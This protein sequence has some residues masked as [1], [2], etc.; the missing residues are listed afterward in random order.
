MATS[1]SFDFNLTRNDIITAAY[2]EIGVVAFGQTPTPDQFVDASLKLNAM[3]KAWKAEGIQLWTITDVSLPIQ[4]TSVVN[5]SDGKDYEATQTHTSTL[6][7]EP[8]TGAN[9]K[10]FWNLLTTTAAGA[11]TVA[12][13]FTS[14]Q[15]YI[16]NQQV[17]G[18]DHAFVRQ[19]NTDTP[20][21][22]LSRFDYNN[23][24]S[25]TTKGKPT[26]FYFKRGLIP[27][28]F[29]Y[30]FPTNTTDFIVNLATIQF[31]QDFDAAS[32]NPDFVQEWLETLIENLALRLA[33]KFGITGQRYA[34]L[35][36][37]ADESKFLAKGGDEE[38]GDLRINP[39][40]RFIDF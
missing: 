34:Q 22:E 10:L 8:I 4:A 38:L 1:G 37:K 40:L 11:W 2:Q 31:P 33:P 29:L 13:A 14:S 20:L 17:F 9:F 19:D 16:L 7:D 28:L 32:D 18:I 23:L 25:K 12:T 21:E 5:G 15:H 30:P 39:S 36:Q 26:Q 35:K 27:E 6:A 3:V 24:A